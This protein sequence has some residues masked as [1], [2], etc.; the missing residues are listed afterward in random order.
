[1]CEEFGFPLNFCSLNPYPPGTE[2]KT[3]SQH[4]QGGPVN[5]SQ[6]D[7]RMVPRLVGGLLLPSFAGLSPFYYTLSI[8]AIISKST[9]FIETSRIDRM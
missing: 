3:F 9:Y 2:G 1:M 5:F 6:P 7:L 8:L 4:L